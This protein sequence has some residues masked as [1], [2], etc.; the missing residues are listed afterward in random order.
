MNKTLNEFRKEFLKSSELIADIS[1]YSDIPD[2]LY[3]EDVYDYSLLF[4]NEKVA[5][6]YICNHYNI[7]REKIFSEL[8]EEDSL[9][10][11]FGK[12]NYLGSAQITIDIYLQELN[13]GLY[14]LW[15][16]Y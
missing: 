12:E 13:D 8:H 14:I 6:D 10:E 7:S 3:G 2:E 15:E 5:I 9:R 11:E 1:K 4:K 16:A